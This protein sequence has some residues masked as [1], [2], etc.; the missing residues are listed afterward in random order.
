MPKRLLL[1]GANRGLGHAI[2]CKFHQEGWLV[3]A[4]NRTPCHADWMHE[5]PCDLRHAAAIPGA[6]EEA[7][8]RLGGLDACICNAATRRLASVETMARL[9]WDESVAV[10]LSAVFALTQLAIPYLRRSQGHL[11]VV[12]SQAGEHFF[13]GG[14]AYCATKAALKAL[15]EVVLL[16]TRVD[17]M[18]TT[19]LSA[20][21]ISNRPLANDGW[22]I[23]PDQV[24]GF[25][26]A[27]VSAPPGAFASE[28][29]LRPAF[30]PASPIRGMQR[31][32]HL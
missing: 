17:G 28:I 29:E 27:L 3:A 15:A 8:S 20:G 25:L 7:V 19:L 5:F 16:E 18:R 21:A 4:L 13:E 10:N 23:S 12:G 22:K 9:D 14:A 26:F 11:V 1:S 6:F 32:Q 31:L 30:P 24:A 2:A